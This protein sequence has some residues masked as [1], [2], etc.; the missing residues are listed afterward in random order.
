MKFMKSVKKYEV[1]FDL[2][3]ERFIWR[4]PLLG[5][6]FIFIGMPVIVLACVSVSTMLI[7]FPVAWIFGL[8]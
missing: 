3:A 6:L 2:K 8:L 7:A 5:F 1:R 4:H